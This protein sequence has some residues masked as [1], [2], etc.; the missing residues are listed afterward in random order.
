MIMKK[1]NKQQV[2]EPKEE[3]PALLSYKEE[4]DEIRHLLS[5][6]CDTLQEIKTPLHGGF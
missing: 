4:L 6:I 2:S 3:T 5:V 1:V